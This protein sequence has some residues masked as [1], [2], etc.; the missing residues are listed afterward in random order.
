MKRLGIPVLLAVLTT[1]SFAAMELRTEN[2]L[3]EDLRPLPKGIVISDELDTLFAGASC[4]TPDGFTAKLKDSGKKALVPNE[5]VKQLGADYDAPVQ[6]LTHSTAQA[7]L[8][9]VFIP[10]AAKPSEPLKLTLASTASYSSTS[11]F[12]LIDNQVTNLAYTM[13][14]SDYFN[15]AIAAG[16]KAPLFGSLEGTAQSAANSKNS[17]LVVRA[18][19]FSPVA[20]AMYPGLGSFSLGED[21]AN[22]ILFGLAMESWSRDKNVPDTTQITS[23]RK[24][25]M[26]WTSNQGSAS[27][28]GAAEI[29][30]NVG[31][32]AGVATL[33]TDASGGATFSKGITY[34]NFNT[35]IVEQQ[36]LGSVEMSVGEVRA[37]L[38]SNIAQARATVARAGND[39]KVAYR[40]IPRNVCVRTWSARRDG[41]SA[42]AS[43]GLVASAWTAADGCVMTYTPASGIAEGSRILLSSPAD[44]SSK[45]LFAPIFALPRSP[46]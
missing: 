41:D 16:A 27:L 2:L 12:A 21:V 7:A 42:G 18:E 43:A 25:R 39:Y 34:S 15:A 3:R 13:S 11:P 24:V 17:V 35:Y 1:Q 37:K 40:S 46:S 20:V 9:T 22:D 28:Q 19:V 38:M 30:A 44:W 33:S 6:F 14:C 32:A 26:I 29:R 5:L 31:L 10:N 4:P 8:H 36:A 45:A 23:W